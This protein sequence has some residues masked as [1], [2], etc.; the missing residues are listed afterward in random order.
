MPHNPDPGA[1]GASRTVVLAARTL[2]AL[3]RLHFDPAPLLAVDH[4]LRLVYTLNEGSERRLHAERRALRLGI[5]LHPWKLAVEERPDL[6]VSAGVGP[7]LHEAGTPVAPIPHGATYN[8]LR[9]GLSGAA[10]TA[11]EHL[12][13][14]DGQAP[15]FMAMPGPAAVEQ[16][17]VD[18]PEALPSAEVA[19]DLCMERLRIS[20]PLRREADPAAQIRFAAAERGGVR[21]RGVRG[22]FAV[23]SGQRPHRPTGGAGGPAGRPPPPVR[24]RRGAAGR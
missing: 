3:A 5:P 10:G 8:R 13:G 9:K 18:C 17:A 1:S 7:E 23:R 12:L 21:V 4:R 15:A 2:Q 16:L 11:R 22:L 24:L 20:V 14:P 6:V 19:G